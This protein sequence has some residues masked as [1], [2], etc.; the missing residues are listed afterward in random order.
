MFF[1]NPE[2]SHDHSLQT[3]NWLYEHDDFMAS[4]DTL[5]D[6]GCGSGLDLEWWATRTT[7][8]DDPR[9]LNIDCIGVDLN[10]QLSIT[11]KYSNITQ[12]QN[13]IL[14]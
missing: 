3:L 6:L 9:P 10:T 8:D 1:R 12:N 2:S 5:V 4:V 13:M 14:L 11:K 7:R